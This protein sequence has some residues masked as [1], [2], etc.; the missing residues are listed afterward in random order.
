MTVIEGRIGSMEKV[1]KEFLPELSKN[2]RTMADI[3]EKSKE[4]G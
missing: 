2:I 4:K 3:V 1:F